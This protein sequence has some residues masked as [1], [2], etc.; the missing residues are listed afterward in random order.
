MLAEAAAA[1]HGADSMDHVTARQTVRRSDLGLA[2]SAAAERPALFQQ[3]RPRRAMDAAVRTAASEQGLFSRVDNGI[4][5]H[6]GYVA[7]NDKK[8]HCTTA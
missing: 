2:G 8:G 5:G 3:L 7:A 4:H 6:F 1:P